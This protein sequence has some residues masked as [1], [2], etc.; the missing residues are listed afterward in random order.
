MISQH[1]V[2]QSTGLPE[3]NIPGIEFSAADQVLLLVAEGFVT[4]RWKQV[5]RLAG[6][7]PDTLEITGKHDDI[8]AKISNAAIGLYS[9]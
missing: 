8:L 4:R 7:S 9:D 1:E 2:L 6:I 5:A 3:D